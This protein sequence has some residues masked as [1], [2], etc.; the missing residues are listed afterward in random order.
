MRAQK[1]VVADHCNEAT[2]VCDCDPREV[3]LVHYKLRVIRIAIIL[4]GREGI[5]IDRAPQADDGAENQQI[6]PMLIQYTHC[7]NNAKLLHLLR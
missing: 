2:I 5:D 6:T 4:D 3:I 7:R 1:D